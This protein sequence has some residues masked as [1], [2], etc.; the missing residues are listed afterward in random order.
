MNR[1]NSQSIK[2]FSVNDNFEENAI[3]TADDIKS[4]FIN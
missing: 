1:E 3:L 4:I 2:L